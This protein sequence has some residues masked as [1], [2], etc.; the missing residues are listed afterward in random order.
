[1]ADGAAPYVPKDAAEEKMRLNAFSQYMKRCAQPLFLAILHQPSLFASAA[2]SCVVSAFM[3][4]P[5]SLR[6]YTNDYMGVWYNYTKGTD[7]NDDHQHKLGYAIVCLLLL[8]SL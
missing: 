4:F 6:L 8:T 2:P 7:V 5:R 3:G 1:M